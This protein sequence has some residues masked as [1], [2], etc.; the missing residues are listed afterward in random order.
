[1]S[2]KSEKESVEFERA[3]RHEPLSAF[4]PKSLQSQY[5]WPVQTGSTTGQPK[6]GSWF[7]PAWT[8]NMGFIDRCLDFYGFPRG[9]NW[10]VAGPS[11]PHNHLHAADSLLKMR[12]GGCFAIDLDPA[13]IKIMIGEQMID[14]HDRYIQHI[15]DQCRN[16][17]QTQEVSVIFTTGKILELI[18]SEV[19]AADLKNVK[20]VMHAGI[21]LSPQTAKEAK[22][23]LGNQ[24][25][26]IGSYGTV[27]TGPAMQVISSADEESKFVYA[28]NFPDTHFE[29]VSS[30]GD[31]VEYGERGQ[32]K[33]YRF[34]SDFMVPG[35]L[36]RDFATKI[37]PIGYLSQISPRG[38]I[39]DPSSPPLLRKGR[40]QGVY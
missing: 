1:V 36:E 9:A 13:F 15:I 21:E 11:G 18:L 37:K 12:G 7:D 6:Y 34:S 10:L 2:F 39:G 23:L 19:S 14:A 4:I 25:P 28:P 24:I 38:W 31:I 5:F 40:S 27:M 33:S 22:R 29:I 26:I 17:L 8:R 32:I 30:S 16:I 20:A 3:L 35:F